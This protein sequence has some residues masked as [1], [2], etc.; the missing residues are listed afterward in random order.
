MLFLLPFF[1]GAIMLFILPYDPAFGYTA[2]DGHCRNGNWMYQ[3][4][5]QSEVAIDVA[6]IG[7]SQTMCGVN[8]SLLD[9]LLPNMR[10]ANL[11]Y[12]R[13]G[14]SLHYAIIEQLMAHKQPSWI[15]LE[16]NPEEDRFSHINFPYIANS[17][18]VLTAP[19]NQRYMQDIWT[20]LQQRFLFWRKKLNGKWQEKHQTAIA[21]HSYLPA[22]PAAVLDPSRV[23]GD[24]RLLQKPL[25]GFGQTE[26]DFSMRLPLYYL[27]KIADLCRERDIKLGFLYLPS[28]HHHPEQLPLEQ[29]KYAEWGKVLI[30]PQEI[31][32]AEN[33]WM[34]PHHFNDIGSDKLSR[35]LAKELVL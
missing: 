32:Q 20:A 33:S 7:S 27:Q 12:C 18:D 17:E 15:I 10:V 6:L 19:L 5:F 4:I 16:I 29:Q 21:N 31:I 22:G 2:I 28:R 8:D 35:W 24:G 13:R 14:R 30:P 11:G 3:R 34:D 1:L 25:D 9:V 26:Y 23:K